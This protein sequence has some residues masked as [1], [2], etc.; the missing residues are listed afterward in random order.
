MCSL[1][2]LPELVGFFSYSREDDE[3]SKGALTKLRERIWRELRAQL[4]RTRSD[5]RL[6]QDTAAIPEGRLWEEEIESAITES[7]FF[8]PIITPTAVRSHHCKR[9]FELFLARE[10]E[11]G[12]K[13]LIF[14]LLYIRTP[15]LED[16]SQWRQDP[17]LKIIGS[18]QYIDWLNFRHLDIDSTEVG[19]ALERFCENISKALHQSWILPKERRTLEEVGA[20]QRAEQGRQEAEA[21]HCAEEA[22]RRKEAESK[23]RVEETSKKEEGEERQRAKD[24]RRR[25]EAEPK[26]LIKSMDRIVKK[27]GSLSH[28]ARFFCTGSGQ[29]ASDWPR[30]WCVCC[31]AYGRVLARFI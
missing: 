7:V 12:R 20:A 2:D 19:V 18:R 6:W 22:E 27:T 23:R 9:E 30:C 21:K 11:L 1:A 17:V 13:D 14:P 3:G 10:T 16:E 8:I 4:G 31:A 29:S 25:Q 28:R 24:E 15:A 26:V 5:F